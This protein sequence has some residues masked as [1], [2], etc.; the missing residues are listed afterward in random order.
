MAIGV[1]LLGEPWPVLASPCPILMFDAKVPAGFPSPAAD[2]SEGRIDL[3]EVLVPHP[4][5]SFTL[6]ISGNSLTRAGILDGALVIVDRSLT[7]RH[8]DIVVAVL[9]GEL[10]AKRLIVRKDRVWLAPDSDDPQ[11]RA[12]EVTGRPDF[13]VWG[14]I[15]STI[16]FLRR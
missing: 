4:S 13:S 9:D 16:N 12:I 15:T 2:F 14:V 3:T 7:A 1:E 8:D 11:Y 6:R 5:A 10:T